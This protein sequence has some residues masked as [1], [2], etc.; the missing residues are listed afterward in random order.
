M[1]SIA[2][3]VMHRCCLTSISVWIVSGWRLACRNEIVSRPPEKILSTA[4]AEPMVHNKQSLALAMKNINEILTWN[5]QE[6][7]SKHKHVRKLGTA[8]KPPANRV[9]GIKVFTREFEVLLKLIPSYA[10]M[11]L[12]SGSKVYLLWRPILRLR[13]TKGRAG[14]AGSSDR[15]SDDI[16]SCI[17]LLEIAGSD[18]FA[19]SR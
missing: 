2:R 17:V 8:S 13:S 10:G 9:T 16:F 11:F 12:V 5:C 14:S 18:A 19:D 6:I 7:T 4:T 1:S 3:R 15:Q